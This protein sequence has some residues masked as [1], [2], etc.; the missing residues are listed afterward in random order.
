M[1]ILKVDHL[2]IAVPNLAAAVKAYEALGFA[3][4]A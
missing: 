3:V 2:G 4:A 1:K